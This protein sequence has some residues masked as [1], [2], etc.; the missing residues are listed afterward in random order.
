M[1]SEYPT[2]SVANAV[3]AP[4]FD[5]GIRIERAV[6]NLIHIRVV[7]KNVGS[8]SHVFLKDHWPHEFTC[9]P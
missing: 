4:W 8:G 7:N 3:C 6:E 9:E 1:T 2:E 5:Y